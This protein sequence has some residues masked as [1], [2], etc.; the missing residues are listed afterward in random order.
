MTVC[1][2]FP[3]YVY[4]EP[5]MFCF[6]SYRTPRIELDCSE[7]EPTPQSFNSPNNQHTKSRG[8]HNT[9]CNESPH[10]YWLVLLQEME[11]RSIHHYWWIPKT[12]RKAWAMV[13]SNYCKNSVKI[14]CRKLLIHCA[15]KLN[16][17]LLT[18]QIWVNDGHYL[19]IIFFSHQCSL[20]N[21]ESVANSSKW[22]FTNF[23]YVFYF[24]VQFIGHAVLSGCTLHMWVPS[25]G[26]KEGMVDCHSEAPH[27]RTELHCD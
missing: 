9:L 16:C 12:R 19:T 2:V 21:C 18:M 8:T 14:L 3:W 26:H 5:F 22:T 20:Q 15:I 24:K 13:H 6:C 23:L 27:G 4:Q 1:I 11:M 17:T 7:Y 25:A 10:D